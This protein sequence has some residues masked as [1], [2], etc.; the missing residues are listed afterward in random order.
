MKLQEKIKHRISTPA[1]V[2]PTGARKE[3]A[4]PSNIPKLEADL[5]DWAEKI[6]A[7]NIK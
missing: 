5:K 2:E 6:S 1:R 4:Q 3:N 7:L